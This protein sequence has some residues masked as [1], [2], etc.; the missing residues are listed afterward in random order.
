MTPKSGPKWRETRL[1]QPI[2][3]IP[4]YNYVLFEPLILY[5]AISGPLKNHSIPSL[6]MISGH[7]T[8]YAFFLTLCRP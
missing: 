5:L 1:I 3:G 4:T 6:V 2:N 7:S 8:F